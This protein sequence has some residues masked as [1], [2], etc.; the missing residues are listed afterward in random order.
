MGGG[1]GGSAAWVGRAAGCAAAAWRA[2]QQV[3]NSVECC[4]TL[5][6]RNMWS[7]QER[8]AD[9]CPR[10]MNSQAGAA[11]P[12]CL[13]NSLPARIHDALLAGGASLIGPNV[14]P[15]GTSV[16]SEGPYAGTTRGT[17][18]GAHAGPDHRQRGGPALATSKACAGEGRQVPC[19][20][21]AASHASCLHRLLVAGSGTGS[22]AHPLGG[23]KTGTSGSGSG[24][25]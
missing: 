14:G 18:S 15:A 13:F 5:P 6:L 10:Q 17:I 7:T 22:G 1:L 20:C 12:V 25:T 24:P 11:A 3:G 8:T 2:V 23:R 19:W 9:H 16:L 4:A 21:S